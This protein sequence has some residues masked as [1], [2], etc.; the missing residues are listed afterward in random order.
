[1]P[2][3]KGVLLDKSINSLIRD[4][5]AKENEKIAIQQIVPDYWRWIDRESR[6]CFSSRV[7]AGMIKCVTGYNYHGQRNAKINNNLCLTKCP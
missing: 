3:R 4:L 5:D 7:G 1:M 2:I 6:N